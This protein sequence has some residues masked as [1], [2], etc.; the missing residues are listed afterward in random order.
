MDT[1]RKGDGSAESSLFVMPWARS[2][3]G[4]LRARKRI[5]N[6]GTRGKPFLFWQAMR[7]RG[8]SA[9]LAGQRLF[10]AGEERGSAASFPAREPRPRGWMG[11]AGRAAIFRK[12]ADA[13]KKEEHPCQ[14]P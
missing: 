12:A 11:I 3:E 6:I 5:G 9:R 1:R 8:E 13:S 7:P 14:R 10:H 2:G 4:P